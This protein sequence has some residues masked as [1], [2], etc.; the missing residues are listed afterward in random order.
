M[1]APGHEPD[2][3]P[4]PAGESPVTVDLTAVVVTVDAE[5][6]SVLVRRLAA[7]ASDSLPWGPLRPEHR[8]LQAGLRA[9]VE[10][11]TRLSLGY[12]EQL[13]TF[14]DRNRA[15]LTNAEADADRRAISVAYL[16]L[17]RASESEPVPEATWQPWYAYLPWEDW[18]AGVPEARAQLLAS[19][20]QWRD[21]ADTPRERRQRGE[22]LSLAFGADGMAWDE[23]RALER[24]ELLYSARLVPEAWYDA[25]Q[26][27]PAWLGALPGRPMAADHRRIL[28]TAIGRLRG[29]IKYRPVLFELLP[30]TFTLLQLQRTAEAISGA[31]LHKQNFR[32]RVSQERLV[33]ETGGVAT[34]TG[35]RPARLMRFRREVTLERPAPGVRV[36]ATRRAS[37]V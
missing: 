23:E 12:I 32:R 4:V 14:G 34:D 9:W 1:C 18:R 22:R 20:E 27:P 10:Q 37:R 5:H 33:E 24:Y 15:Q 28:A 30:P 31:R 3:P 16:A 35:G 2:L 36:T 8:T 25:G 13:Y 21:A 19:L 26:S 29:K 17:V 11:Q 7:V 6:P